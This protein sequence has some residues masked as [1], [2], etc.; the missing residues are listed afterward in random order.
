FYVHNNCAKNTNTIPLNTWTFLVGTWDG[1]NVYVY[2]NGVLANSGACTSSTTMK[3]LSVGARFNGS[4]PFA[5]QIDEVQVWNKA[6]TPSDVNLLYQKGSLKYTLL[7]GTSAGDVNTSMVVD[8]N[9]S[10]FSDFNAVDLNSPNVPSAP[11][12]SG[13][14]TSTLDVNWSSVSDNGSLYYYR[15]YCWF[16]AVLAA[17]FESIK[18]RVWAF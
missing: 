16:V 11:V 12:V 1:N 17:G 3:T 6:L 15:G 14:T 10:V 18:Q 5:G 7:R 4:L 9:S 13:A 8:L 2:Q